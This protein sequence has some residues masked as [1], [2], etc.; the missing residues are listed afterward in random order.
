M[1]SSIGI[2]CV[3]SALVVA[4][5]NASAAT[6][7]HAQNIV[8][9][10]PSESPALAEAGA[11]ALFLHELG[12]GKTILYVEDQGGR[13]LSIL[14]ITNPGAIKL[15]GHAEI[16]AKGPFDF[17]SNLDD[18][19]VLIRYRGRSGFALM[20]LKHWMR[21][22]ILEQPELG[23]ATSAKSF[24]SNGLL[25]VSG[26]VLPASARPVQS[27]DVV[28]TSDVSRPRTLATIPAVIQ[29]VSNADT[30]TTFLLNPSG[31]TVVRRLDAEQ[32]AL[33]DENPR[34]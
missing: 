20:D 11:E 8:I 32:R 30:G 31:I 15:A 13:A 3:I 6:R 19:G 12:N 27:Y 16:S 25:L 2:I 28:D 4:G 5:I 10:S 24:G 1:K 34:N 17:V 23:K 9:N 33:E 14:D 22:S 21:P 7:H 29:R 18:D 26:N